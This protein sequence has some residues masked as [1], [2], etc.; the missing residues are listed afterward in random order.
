MPMILVKYSLGT[1]LSF[2]DRRVKDECSPTNGEND[3]Q[4]G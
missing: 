4:K 2:Y 3:A 1:N